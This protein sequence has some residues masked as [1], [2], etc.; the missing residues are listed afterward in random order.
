MTAR[1]TVLV[2]DDTEAHRY[3]MASWLRRAGYVVVEASTGFEA[4]RLAGGHL[5]AIILDVNLPDIPGPQV[6][7]RLKADPATAHVPV[8]H[9]SATS[10]DA[11]SRAFGLEQGADAYLAE[12]LDEGEFLA[13]VG[14]LGRTREAHRD[15]GRTV[16]RMERLTEALVPLHEARSYEQVVDAAALG[17]SEVLGRAV[18]AMVVVDGSLVLRT[19]AS[20][21]QPLVRSTGDKPVVGVEPNVPSVLALRHI[22]APWHELLAQSIV[23]PGDW[24]TTMLAD[25]DG[26]TVGGLGVWQA[27]REPVTEEDVAATRRFGEAM[28]V[29]LSNLRSFAEEHKIA[30]ALQRAML[31]QSLP[32]DDALDIAVRYRASEAMLAVGGDFYDA[33]TLDD[34][35]TVLVIGDVQGHSLRAAT[36]MGELRISLR[37][38]LREGHPPARALDLLNDLLRDSHPEYVSVCVCV[39][40][41]ATGAVELVN[42]G[43]LPPLAVSAD[44]ESRYLRGSSR[45]LGM[46]LDEPRPTYA[47]E[48][49]PGESLVLVTDGLV[50]R[51]GVSLRSTL[52]TL[53]T[54]AAESPGASPDQLCDELLTRFAPGQEDDVAVLVARRPAGKSAAPSHARPYSHAGPLVEGAL[55]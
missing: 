8:L 25:G 38:Y 2:V 14:A 51:R 48:L 19:L 11:Q 29:A 44:G 28:T 27:L 34:G 53:A 52:G 40:D 35:R 54:V 31:P 42:A 13:T 20:E 32:E 39:V 9:V 1:S 3:V 47:H 15:V 6:C 4:L 45:I 50:E 26:V 46:P 5:D 49:A 21:G 23:P 41:P 12:P 18:I 43:H 37:A 7:R 22:P 33:F 17:A 55:G 16:L 24:Y 30:L 10:I 36:V